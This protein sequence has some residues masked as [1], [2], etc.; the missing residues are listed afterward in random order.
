MIA[1]MA[2]AGTVV[3]PVTVLGE[4]EAAFELGRR[5]RENRRMLAELLD[6]EFVS[7]WPATASVARHYGQLFAQ[8]KRAG[9]P[10]PVN[11]VWIAA[12]TIDCSGELLT[13][14]TDYGR[15]PGLNVVIL[16]LGT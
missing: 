8:L 10:V 9:T 5:G 4:L 13:F 6:E 11:D 3:L 7:V 2:A 16:D 12:V 14:D 15:I 1:R